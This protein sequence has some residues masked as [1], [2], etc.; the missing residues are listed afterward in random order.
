MTIIQKITHRRIHIPKNH[1]S[2]RYKFYASPFILK[3]EKWNEVKNVTDYL[4]KSFDFGIRIVE[5]TRWL[6]DEGKEFPLAGRLLESGTGVGISLRAAKALPEQSYYAQAVQHAEEVQYLLELM[7]DTGFITEI[8]SKP[9]LSGCKAIKK[10]AESLLALL[11]DTSEKKRKRA[12]KPSPRRV[13][14]KL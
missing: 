14:M 6:K 3:A 8:Q 2:M 9:L 10:Q 11:P 7:V 13:K 12:K 4:S 1:T 5:L